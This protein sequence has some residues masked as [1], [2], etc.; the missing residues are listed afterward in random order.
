MRAF[1]IED[2]TRD[3]YLANAVD[4]VM[5]TN[6]L[7]G[8]PAP[9]SYQLSL[10]PLV[11]GGEVGAMIAIDV[12]NDGKIF[13]ERDD[14]TVTGAGPQFKFMIDADPWHQIRL[15]VK[16]VMEGTKASFCIGA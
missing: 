2:L 10:L 3:Q 15:R 13:I 9:R 5:T 8:M 14:W 16:D 7:E 4:L 1:L 11:D 12:S 6:A